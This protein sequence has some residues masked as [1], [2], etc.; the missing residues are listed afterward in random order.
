MLRFLRLVDR[1]RREPEMLL[2]IFGRTPLQMRHLAAEALEMPVH[3][4]RRRG[5][6]AEPALDEHDL[7]AREALRD[8]F[9][10]E[11][12]ELRRHRMRVTLV[13]L[14]IKRRPAAA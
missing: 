7:Q 2:H 4:P 14:D 13:L 3:P 6:P 5:N 8:A 10:H 1:L 9:E 12:R 11:A